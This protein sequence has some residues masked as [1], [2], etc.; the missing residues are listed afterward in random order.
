[1]KRLKFTAVLALTALL[2]VSCYTDVENELEGLERRL[3]NINKKVTVIND[4]IA[5]LQTIAD[6]YKAYV[7]IENYRPVYQGKDIIGYTINFTD[8]TSIT[9]KNGVSKDDPIVGLQLGEDGLYYWT[10]TVGG[11]TDFL[12]DET[13]Q[14]VAAS[15]ASP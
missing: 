3:D 13:G 14:P 4:N 12:Y 1:M 5:S 11:K 15:V 6:K 2:A 9:L 7:Y 10:V 8:G